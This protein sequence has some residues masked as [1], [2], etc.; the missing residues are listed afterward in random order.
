MLIFNFFLL[1]ISQDSLFLLFLGI[2]YEKM[3]RN[4]LLKC[5]VMNNNKKSLSPP[6]PKEKL[7]KTGQTPLLHVSSENMTSYNF[8]QNV[9]VYNNKKY[10]YTDI[11]LPMRFVQLIICNNWSVFFV[12][13]YQHSWA[14]STEKK[15]SKKKKKR[16]FFFNDNLADINPET[17]P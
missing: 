10:I 17:D 15:Y 12:A 13:S 8:H 11:S 6:A 1:I 2:G 3:D 7:S 16:M 5:S 9:S 4:V 14:L